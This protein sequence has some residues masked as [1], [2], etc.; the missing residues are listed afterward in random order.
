ML[1]PSRQ[2]PDMTDTSS[3]QASNADM[4]SEA[5]NM[6]FVQ[7]ELVLALQFNF[8]GLCLSTTPGQHLPSCLTLKPNCDQPE[9]KQFMVVNV[10][11]HR[12]PSIDGC[13]LE[14][15]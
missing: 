4:F 15:S 2:Q 9:A 5:Y 6:E 13:P 1:E 8:C 12:P 10:F 3:I 14:D 7:S 11:K